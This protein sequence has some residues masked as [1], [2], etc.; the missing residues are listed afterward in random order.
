MKTKL[1][2]FLALVLSGPV[3]NGQDKA[4]ECTDDPPACRFRVGSRADRRGVGL[5]DPLS[6]RANSG[7]IRR[8]AR[9]G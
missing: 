2:L 4:E 6:I 9:F 1:I 5:M 7:T 3:V 8:A